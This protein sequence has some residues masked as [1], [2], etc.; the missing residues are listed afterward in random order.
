ML[1]FS[2]LKSM[3]MILSLSSGRPFRAFSSFA[4]LQEAFALG[5]QFLLERSNPSFEF[6][7]RQCDRQIGIASAG[8]ILFLGE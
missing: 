1:F 3:M 4:D 2:I 7:Q 5:S 8:L 6:L